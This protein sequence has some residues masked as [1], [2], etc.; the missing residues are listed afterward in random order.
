MF[1]AGDSRLTAVIA[2]NGLTAESLASSTEEIK[3][4]SDPGLLSGGSGLRQLKSQRGSMDL[5]RN[6]SEFHGN[7]DISDAENRISCQDMYIS[8]I[9]AG[10]EAVQGKTYDPDADPFELG[11]ESMIP[12]RLLFGDGLELKNV[13]CEKEVLMERTGEHG[14]KQQAGGDRCIYTVADQMVVLTSQP[15]ERPWLKGNGMKQ[16][17]DKILFDVGK[18]IFTSR[19]K[20]V[21]S[22]E[23]Q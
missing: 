23:D 19:G 18:G 1:Q 4:P 10:K 6:T 7:V 2:E 17:S 5:L 3:K 15:P 16:T 13:I 9:P 20:T 11:S 12:S 14:M 8:A 21:T 22:R